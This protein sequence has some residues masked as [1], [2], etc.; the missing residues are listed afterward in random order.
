MESKGE[1]Q[2]SAEFDPVAASFVDGAQAASIH[3]FTSYA[4]DMW[5]ATPARGAQDDSDRR[6]MDFV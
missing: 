6:R 5:C 1:T 4:Q 2:T 3:S